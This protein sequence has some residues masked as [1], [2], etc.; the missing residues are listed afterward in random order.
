MR[1]VSLKLRALM[2]QVKRLASPRGEKKALA[3]RL[4]ISQSKL[5]D[6]LAG[7]YE[8]GGDLTL[9][10]LAWVRAKEAKQTKSPGR[11][12]PRPEPKTQLRKSSYEKPKSGRKKR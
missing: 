11:E 4:G 10:L 1:G 6:Y 5:S 12:S 8:P 7:V 3:S 9:Q 2:R